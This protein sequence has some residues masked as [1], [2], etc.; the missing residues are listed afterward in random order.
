MSSYATPEST[1]ATENMVTEN[2]VSDDKKSL[3]T[4]S[5]H[6]NTLANVASAL[7]EKFVQP[8]DAADNVKNL[9][10]VYRKK[11]V[12]SASQLLAH[13]YP[14]EFAAENYQKSLRE[15]QYVLMGIGCFIF[16]VSLGWAAIPQANF[17]QGGGFI[18][19]TGLIGGVLMLVALIYSVFKRVKFLRRLITSDAWYYIH[20]GCG[21]IG[22]YLVIL[23]SSFDLGSINSAVAFFAM[24]FVI[25]SGALGRY[26]YTLSSISLHKQFAE[27]EVTEPD[28]FGMIDKYE[29]NTSDRIRK[30][31]SRFALHCFN[32]P[33][34]ILHYMSRY[35]SVAYYGIHFYVLS[36]QDLKRIIRSISV[37]ADLDKK[38]VKV[39]QKVQ[40]RRLRQYVIQIV[41]M[42]YTALAEQL[43][44]NWRV[45]HVPMLYLLA[46]TAVAH[47]VV[48]HMY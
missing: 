39:L 4:L 13:K 23:H 11:D 8:A 30:R 6:E 41:K 26:L 10:A 16:L 20:I 32:Q 37:L 14:V 47:V 46:I 44:K 15:L 40:K 17:V 38:D 33:S 21:A 1:V 18:Y 22:S 7:R 36:A 43:L 35:F 9:P 27:I 3:V 48:V 42:G 31:L 24:L 25:I 34:D 5:D 29:C 28:L 12:V 19:N 2:V 45:L